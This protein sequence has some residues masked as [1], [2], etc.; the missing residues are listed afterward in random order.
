MTEVEIID[1]SQEIKNKVKPEL[2]SLLEKF[3]EG[4]RYLIDVSL[5]HEVT[6]IPRHKGDIRKFYNYYIDFVWTAFIAKFSSL[7]RGL[8]SV[9]NRED[10]LTYGLIGRAM[11]ENTAVLRHY[12][13]EE[14]LPRIQ[15]PIKR[16]SVKGRELM[17]ITDIL[18][19]CVR[20]KCFDWR[21]FFSGDFNNLIKKR[22]PHPHVKQVR[23]GDC[24]REWEKEKPAIGVLYGIFCDFV[25]PNIG[26]TFLVMRIR[27]D[28]IGFG[29][30]RGR[31]FGFDL[32]E[33]TFP[34]L[35][36]VTKEYA[37]LLTALFLLRYA[38]NEI[39]KS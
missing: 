16:K 18:D 24:I 29:G 34:A 9:V 20:G 30:T 19:K 1:F 7:E 8:I 22:R 13:R 3:A 2:R 32:F 28:S 10:F 26:S 31:S 12:L 23:V 5:E 14:I 25:H 35:T 38:D 11:I 6:W 39:E 27:S 36:G 21:S 15:E 4:T 37:N 33:R 17:E